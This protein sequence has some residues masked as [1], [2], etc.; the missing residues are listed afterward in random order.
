LAA[1]QGA[2]LLHSGK[3]G[4]RSWNISITTSVTR[5]V[6]Q[7]DTKFDGHIARVGINY[8]FGAPVVAKY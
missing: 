3:I 6:M 4:A 5:P 2:G 7:A 1:G 8:K